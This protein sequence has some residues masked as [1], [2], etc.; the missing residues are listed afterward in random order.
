[1]IRFVNDMEL[2]LIELESTKYASV[3]LVH[4]AGKG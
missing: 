1:M 3:E 4:S 2:T